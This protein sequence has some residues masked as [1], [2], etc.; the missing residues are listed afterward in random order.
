LKTEVNSFC[1]EQKKFHLAAIGST[2]SQVNYQE[3]PG[4]KMATSMFIEKLSNLQDSTRFS[5]ESRNYTLSESRKS[6]IK[7]Y[8]FQSGEQRTVLYVGMKNERFMGS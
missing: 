4:M 5:P 2:S 8:S 1:I 7:S 6:R 3:D